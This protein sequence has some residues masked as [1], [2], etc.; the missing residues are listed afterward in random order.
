MVVSRFRT[1]ITLMLIMTCQWQFVPVIRHNFILL[2]RINGYIVIVLVMISNAGTF[3]IIR[4]SF[5]GTLPTQAAMG[6]LVILSTTSISMA[7]YNIKRLQIEQHRAWMLRAMF[8]LGVIITT[9]IIM[10]IAAQVSTAVG[11]Y[12]VPMICDEIVFVQDSL[13][14]NNTMYPQCSIA[15]MTV[16]GMIAVAANFGSDRREQLQASLELNFG[17]AAWLSIFLHTIGV[18]IYLN[19]TPAEGE[20]LRRISYAKQLEAGM[21]NPGSAGLT[22]DRWGDADEWIMPAE[23]S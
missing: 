21:K 18:E 10:V 6:L 20:C 19:L 9:R 15:N 14:H 16:D 5:G 2:H 23:D 8:Y 13:T 11:K 22:V 1:L 4:R 12:Y 3:L 7:Y 17:M